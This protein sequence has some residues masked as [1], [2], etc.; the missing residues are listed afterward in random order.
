MMLAM[1]GL[2]A[3]GAITAEFT[4]GNGTSSVDQWTGIAGDGWAGGWTSLLPTGDS[5]TVTSTT[6]LNGA[7]DNYLSVTDS[8]AGGAGNHNIVRSI[9]SFGDVDTSQKYTIRWK[10]RFDGSVTDMEGGAF[11]DRIHFYGNNGNTNGTSA[12]NSWVVGWASADAGTLT[13]FDDHWY[14]FDNNTGTAF[15]TSNQIDTGIGLTAGVVY[16]FVV[17]VD[18]AAGTYDASIDD[19][20]D[21]FSATGLTF[22]NGLTGQFNSLHFGTNTS[23]GSFDSSY[24]LDSVTISAVTVVPSPTAL[25]AGLLMLGAM[26]MRRRC[27]DHA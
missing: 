13:V 24:A 22:R 17:T 7:G 9:T 25:P 16:E 20:T 6:P 2:P 23:D 4:D 3:S 19:G 8:T 10:W 18:P 12:T 27:G 1:C 5:A 15:N 14:F 26:A 11:N 21:N